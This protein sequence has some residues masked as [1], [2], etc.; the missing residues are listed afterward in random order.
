MRPTVL[1]AAALAILTWQPRP[2]AATEGATLLFHGNYCGP[3]N[4]GPGV[5]PTDALDRACARHDACTPDAGL[6]TCACNDRL[7]A[8][9]GAVSDDP[10]QPGDLRALA[11]IVSAGAVALA[12]RPGAYGPPP[13]PYVPARPIPYEPYPRVIEHPESGMYGGFVD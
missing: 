3:G 12:C 10:R 4:R 6:P 1:A 8:E 11:G 9:A 5:P 13:P 2:A 7:R